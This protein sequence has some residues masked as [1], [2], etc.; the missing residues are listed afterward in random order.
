MKEKFKQGRFLKGVLIGLALTVVCAFPAGAESGG[1]GCWFFDTMGYH[2]MVQTGYTAPSCMHPGL[3][4]EACQVCGTVSYTSLPKLD[5]SFVQTGYTETSC[6]HPGMILE[7]CEMCGLERSISIPKL[8]HTFVATGEM[9]QS[10]CQTEGWY[11][12]QCTGCGLEERVPIPMVGHYYLATGLGQASTCQEEGYEIYR[13]AW[14]SEETTYS[15]PRKEHSY[16]STG[17]EM[18]STC[19]EEGYEVL[20]CSMCGEEIHEPLPLTPHSF[21]GWS[22]SAPATDHSM[23]RRSR[24]CSVCGETESEEYY[25][26]GTLYAWDT[27]GEEVA[28]LQSMLIDLGY[29]YDVA[30]G[31]FGSNTQQAVLSFQ[32]SKGLNEDGIAWPQTRSALYNEWRSNATPEQLRNNIYMDPQ[33]IAQIVSGNQNSTEKA[34]ASPAA[35][36]EDKSGAEGSGTEGK[37]SAAGTGTE[38]QGGAAGSAAEGKS[39][40]EGSGPAENEDG[41]GTADNT[42]FTKLLQQENSLRLR[43]DTASDYEPL[44]ESWKEELDLLYQEWAERSDEQQKTAITLSSGEFYEQAEQM[45]SVIAQVDEMAA[46]RWYIRTLR[47]ECMLLT[48]MP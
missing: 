38:G 39:G 29:L 10:T 33:I 16:V 17:M 21:G 24:T 4:E 11:M 32:A 1:S 45:R 12:T 7:Q 9:Q 41:N 8:D 28:G 27:S 23:G 40:A 30:D 22:V 20:R 43:T 5:H 47:D 19:T 15:L 31:I 34:E 48:E 44:A 14:C 42:R 6:M 35:G 26:D 13:C 46:I 3:V 36:T 37:S 25:P 18:P 2:N